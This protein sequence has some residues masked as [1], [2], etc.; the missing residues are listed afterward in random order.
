MKYL[1]AA[2]DIVSKTLALVW[3]AHTNFTAHQILAGQGDFGDRDT[4]VAVVEVR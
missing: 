4:A 3:V 2:K 1:N